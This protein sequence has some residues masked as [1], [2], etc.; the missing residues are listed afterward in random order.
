MRVPKFVLRGTYIVKID[1]VQ[2]KLFFDRV[3]KHSPDIYQLRHCRMGGRAVCSERNTCRSRN[4]F[5]FDSYQNHACTHRSTSSRSILS[6]RFVRARVL[7]RLNDRPHLINNAHSV[8]WL[9]HGASAHPMIQRSNSQKAK[10]RISFRLPS[11]SDMKNGAMDQY[12][13]N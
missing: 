9:L 13:V 10:V 7:R 4:S 3:A 5:N 6:S 12:M 8:S 2:L 11:H 1:K